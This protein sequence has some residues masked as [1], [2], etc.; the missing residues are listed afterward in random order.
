MEN[1]PR[2]LA[3]AWGAHYAGLYYTAIS[4]RLTDRGDEYIVNDCGARVFITSTYKA[5]APPTR[6][7]GAER[8]DSGS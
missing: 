1:H 5:E 7:P 6:R 4:S 8:L 3:I 2:F